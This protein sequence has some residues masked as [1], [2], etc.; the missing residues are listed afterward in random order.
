MPTL[1]DIPGYQLDE[2]VLESPRTRIYRAHSPSQQSVMIR[3]PAS[4]HPE[5][6]QVA[7]YRL[8]YELGCK[9]DREAVVRHLELLRLRSSVALITENF[10]D[11]SL[12]A[13]IPETGFRLRPLLEKSLA[14]AK[15]LALLHAGGILHR[16]VKPGNVMVDTRNDR[17]RFIDLETAAELNRDRGDPITTA[18]S[19][20]TLPYTSPE[21]CGCV[22]SPVDE[23]ADLYSL[24]VTLFQMA[25]GR[26]PF[27]QQDPSAL[28]HAHIALPPPR[29]SDERNDLPEAFCQ[30][31]ARLL[32]KNMEDRYSSA[33]GVVHDLQQCVTQYHRSGTVQHFGIA[34]NDVSPLFR[35][36]D[37]LYGR[38]RE[39]EQLRNAYESFRRGNRTVV[40]VSGVSGIGKT[41]FVEH[42]RRSTVRGAGAFFSGKY[43]QFKRDQPYFGLIQAA[44]NLLRF[45]L[46]QPESALQA[47]RSALRDALGIHARLLTDVLPELQII[48]GDQPE[49]DQVAPAAA[50]RRFHGLVARFLRVFATGQTTLVIFIDDFQWADPPSLQLLEALAHG[51]GL[52]HVMFILGYRSNELGGGDPAR[53]TLAELKNTAQEHCDIEL[54]PLDD[55]ETCALVQATLHRSDEEARQLAA[56]IHN[57]AAGNV[58]FVR[59]LL[60]ALNER[61]FFHFDGVRQQWL[62]DLLQLAGQGV[63]DNVVDLLT[64][65][66]KGLPE[67]CLDLLDT[68]SCVGSEFDLRTI[69]NVHEIKQSEAAAQ[70]APAVHNGLLVPLDGDY[71]VFEMLSDWQMDNAAMLKLGTARYRFQHDQVRHRV[72][73]RLDSEQRSQRH[74]K[75]GRLLLRTLSKEELETNVVEVFNHLT[76]GAQRLQNDQERHTYARLGLRS[77]RAAQRGLAF[78]TARTQLNVATTLLPPD[79]WAQDYETVLGIKLTLAEC[80]FALGNDEDFEAFTQ[81]I[82]TNVKDPIDAARVHGLY[83]RFLSTA[84]RYAE[85]VDIGVR[86]ARFLGVALPRKPHALHVLAGVAKALWAQGRRDHAALENIPESN[87]MKTNE[88]INLLN[89]SSSAA[90]FSEPNL[91]PLIGITST[92][93]SLRHGLNPGSPYGFAVWALVLC[94]VLGQIENGYG[95]GSLALKVG[96]RYGGVEEARARFVVTAFVKHWKEPLA[97][98]AK[99]LLDDWS[100]NRDAGDDESAVYSAGV[101]LYTDFLSGGSLDADQRHPEVVRYIRDN[102]KLHVKDCFLAWI[103]LFEALRAPLL[104]EQLSGEW[105]RFAE[106]MPEFERTHNGVQ[107]AI[108]SIAQGILDFFAG[109]FAIAE[110]HFA[111]AGR[112]KDNI[113]AQVLVPGLAFYRALNAY[114]LYAVN[115][116]RRVLAIARRRTAR[117]QKWAK[118]APFNLDHRISLLHAE[119][120]LVRR[121]IDRAVMHLHQACDQ[122][123]SGAVLYQAL[124][125]QRLS[126]IFLQIGN[127]NQAQLNASRAAATFK[128]WGAPA[129]V[130]RMKFGSSLSTR[131][132][133]TSFDDVDTEPINTEK[134]DLRSLTETIGAIS[135]EIDQEKLLDRLMTT[136]MQAANAD[137]GLLILTDNDVNPVVEV[138][139]RIGGPVQRVRKALDAYPDLAGSVVNLTLRTGKMTVVADA[140]SDELVTDVA[141]VKRARV[142]AILASGV[143]VQG[144]RIGVIYL[145]NHL[146]RNAFTANRVEV[147]EALGSQAGIA[148]ENARLYQSVQDA[149]AVQTALTVANRRFVPEEVL[150]GLG[151]KSIIDV[152]LNEAIERDMSV[153]FADLRNFTALSLQLGARRTIQMVNRYLSHVQPGIAANHGFVGEYRGD[154]FIALFP[155]DA[156]NALNGA[157]AMCQGLAGYNR[158]RGDFPALRFGI[159]IHSGPV[160]LGLI[161]DLDHIQLGVMGDTANTASRVEGLTKHFGATVLLTN[162]SYSRLRH[163]DRFEL[164][165]LGKVEVAG[166]SKA[167]QVYEC[168]DAYPEQLQAALLSTRNR[169]A[170]AVTLYTEGQWILAHAGFSDCLA[171][172][173]EDTVSSRFGERCLSRSNNAF[174][175]DGVERPAKSA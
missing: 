53:R 80:A 93:L 8:A 15:A 102:N 166:R 31:V 69:A 21:Q 6:A 82:L 135:S 128:R 122:A 59:E 134:M 34:Q 117:L 115:P 30:I 149:L 37:L 25:A 129:L 146:A 114:R 48:L 3:T 99:L 145:E 54:G 118:F 110:K 77:A 32:E 136:L 79:P 40:T 124:A 10:G 27:R 83:I 28:V 22:N 19:E 56:H 61:R 71:K 65:R 94:G 24:G 49:V 66:L 76:Y 103:E 132:P 86:V 89:Q 167:I 147:I 51:D 141:Y 87:D 18:Q 38:E 29:L 46:S 68:A 137:R 92:R 9:A 16:D 20:G 139:A 162:A 140:A 7:R 172:C 63:P 108:S 13:L 17:L 58:F 81:Q 5:P 101:L 130:N 23:R 112:F 97:D 152:E 126:E 107:I 4:H 116:G 91:L 138:Q 42:M 170:E 133:C 70:L 72:H 33:S 39:S 73:Q 85:A 163:H 127:E 150:T 143:T 113:V 168:L 125:E 55:S 75:I 157:V 35:V 153:M 64:H 104:P 148:L 2:L 120:A 175:W 171:V 43:D 45:E 109:R 155:D 1:M 12:K 11:T 154:S 84:T 121:R 142:R 159:G 96:R 14:L 90:Y 160:T 74:L 119:E 156:E 62:W 144:R 44:R 57:V 111:T 67:T 151:V 52:N 131:V 164:R 47:R 95:F 36:S 100:F 41:A 165:S 123:A 173:P 60:L 169:F 78:E 174:Q 161:G 98:V 158:E 106:K 26:L 50:A 88:A 105:F